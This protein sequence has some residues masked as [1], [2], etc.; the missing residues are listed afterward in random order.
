MPTKK[1]TPKETDRAELVLLQTKSS[2]KHFRDA[3]NTV[4]KQRSASGPPTAGEQDL[5][6]GS[7]KSLAEEDLE[8]HR[9]LEEYAKRQLRTDSENKSEKSSVNFL[10]KILVSSSPYDQ[11]IDDY[12]IHLTG[13]SLQSV[14]ELFKASSA[15]GIT[16][17]RVNEKSEQN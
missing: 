13:S 2:V 4:R 10:A 17:E 16:I 12:T 9:G 8:V 3:F 6:R 5:I 14:D 1:T 11:L 15:L 7:I